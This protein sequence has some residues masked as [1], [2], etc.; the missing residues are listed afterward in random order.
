VRLIFREFVRAQSILN[1]SRIPAHRKQFLDLDKWT[2]KFRC[3]L[4][5]EKVLNFDQQEGSK[6]FEKKGIMTTLEPKPL[7]PLG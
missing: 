2:K 1:D 6:I 3:L 5:R 7:S 4:E